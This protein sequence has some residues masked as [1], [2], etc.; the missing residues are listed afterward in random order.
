MHQKIDEKLNE[1]VKSCEGYLL[2]PFPC[3]KCDCAERCL[4]INK[5]EFV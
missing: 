1:F 2:I 3:V 5:M 4:R